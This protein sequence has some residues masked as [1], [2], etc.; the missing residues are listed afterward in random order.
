MFA[1]ISLTA[2]FLLLVAPPIGCASNRNA[3]S[4]ASN[5]RASQPG[6][7]V[8]QDNPANVGTSDNDNNSDSDA[9]DN[10]ND[11][12]NDSDSNDNDDNQNGDGSQ[13]NEQNAAGG[14]DQPAQANGGDNDQNDSVP[15]FN[16]QQPANPNQ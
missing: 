9:S 13:M 14:D 16:Q 12:D 10:D 6:I 7:V 2:A 4:P 5:A 11:K 8:A 1:K 3:T 15:Q